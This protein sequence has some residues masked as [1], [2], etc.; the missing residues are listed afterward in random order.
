MAI[1]DVLRSSALATM[2]ALSPE[3]KTHMG[4]ADRNMSWQKAHEVKVRLGKGN[5]GWSLEGR[6][7][8]SEGVRMPKACPWW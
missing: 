6:V 4:P 8:D 7:M 2:C 1:V 5:M 3:M